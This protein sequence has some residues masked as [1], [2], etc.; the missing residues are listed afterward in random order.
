MM[1][2][3]P[4]LAGHQQ[5]FEIS[6]DIG[7]DSDGAGIAVFV[8]F[9]DRVCL[10]LLLR[11]HLSPLARAHDSKEFSIDLSQLLSKD[12]GIL[13]AFQIDRGIVGTGWGRV[14]R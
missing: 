2:F 8:E 4:H 7:R 11:I 3:P 13:G 14:F 10:S 6:N 9:V 1:C 5:G 12:H